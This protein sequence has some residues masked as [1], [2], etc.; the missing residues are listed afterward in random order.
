MPYETGTP[1]ASTTALFAQ[2]HTEAARAIAGMRA[3]GSARLT[4]STKKGEFLIAMRRDRHLKLMTSL[5]LAESFSALDCILTCGAEKL[6][7]W[8]L[9][10][11]LYVRVR[12]VRPNCGCV[13]VEGMELGDRTLQTQ[14]ALEPCLNLTSLISNICTSAPQSQT[15]LGSHSLY[16]ST[17]AL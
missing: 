16:V 2:Q 15:I 8:F 10:C 3:V 5:M 6:P 7:I 11:C 17:A 4:K 13:V 12:V 1:R 9:S 14:S